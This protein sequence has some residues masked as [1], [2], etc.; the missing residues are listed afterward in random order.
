MHMNLKSN[1]T[2]HETDFKYKPKKK[3]TL[4]FQVYGFVPTTKYIYSCPRH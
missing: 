3:K 2:G 1:L 4:Q